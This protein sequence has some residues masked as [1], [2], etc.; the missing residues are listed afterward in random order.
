MRL[1]SCSKSATNRADPE[2][3]Q[4]RQSFPGITGEKKP[5]RTRDS[6]R[7]SLFRSPMDIQ[8]SLRVCKSQQVEDVIR[9]LN[10]ILTGHFFSSVKPPS[11]SCPHR[12]VIPLQRRLVPAVLKR[13]YRP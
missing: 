12:T 13:S 10:P 5:P 3:R 4:N 1:L 6:V 7:A 2:M 8:A 11:Q 9:L